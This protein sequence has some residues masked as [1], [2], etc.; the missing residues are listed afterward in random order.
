[1]N[2][3]V[4]RESDI[5]HDDIRMGEVDQNLGSPVSDAEQ[6][7]SGIDRCHQVEVL[8]VDDRLAHLLTH[9]APCAEHADP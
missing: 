8:G 2:S 1:M 4:H 5:V 7:V 3:L 6:P 9:S